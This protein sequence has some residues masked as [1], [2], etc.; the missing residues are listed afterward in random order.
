MHHPSV[1]WHI[2]PM[3]ISSWN[4]VWFGKKEPIRAQIFRLLSALMKVH[5]IP[6]AILKP[7]IQ[8]LFQFCINVQCHERLLLCIYVAQ[9]LH[10]IKER[11]EKKC[12]DFWVVEW[13]LTKLLMSRLKPQVSFSLTFASLFSVV[14]DNSSTLLAEILYD[15]GKRK[16]LLLKN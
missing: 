15:L 2:I 13:K 6:H 5:P 8:G 10:L 9:T 7:Q 11:I 14:G 1:S 3:K 12:W 4:I 16:K